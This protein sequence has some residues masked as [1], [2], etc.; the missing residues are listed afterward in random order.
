MSDIPLLVCAHLPTHFGSSFRAHVQCRTQ[1]LALQ[2]RRMLHG[3]GNQ[4]WRTSPLV[5]TRSLLARLLASSLSVLLASCGATRSVVPTNTEDLSR[6]VLIIRE[7]GDGRVIHTWQRAEEMDL[8]QYRYRASAGGATGHVVRVSGRRRDCDQEL[9]D[10]HRDCMR[11]PVPPDYN[12]YEYNR[13]IGGRAD[14]CNKQC[15]T[16]YL[17]CKEQQRAR[18]VEFTAVD[19]AVDWL[20]RN[21][22]EVIVGSAIVIAGVAFVVVSAGAGVVVIAPALLL[23]SHTTVSEPNIAAVSP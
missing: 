1:A 13:G 14:Y 17:D 20:K 22:K 7:L 5:R 23:A 2:L 9:I 16:P 4:T 19:S 10:C 21:R 11:R 15:L 12:Q 3:H 8:S 18:P 6:L